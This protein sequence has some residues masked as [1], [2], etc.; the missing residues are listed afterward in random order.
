LVYAARKNECNAVRS[1]TPKGRK[2]ATSALA[3]TDFNLVC[4][5]LQS[6]DKE[7]RAYDVMLVSFNY[8]VIYKTLNIDGDNF[9]IEKSDGVLVRPKCALLEP[10]NEPNELNTV[11]L[12][13][14]FGGRKAD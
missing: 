9:I 14:H 8:P 4:K 12:I 5:N 7:P 1:A 2:D 10:T 11:H 6:I 3:L 13:G